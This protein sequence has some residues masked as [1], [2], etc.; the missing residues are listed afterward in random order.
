MKSVRRISLLVII[1]IGVVVPSVTRNAYFLAVLITF[2]I[3]TIL[4][5][6]MDLGLGRLGVLPFGHAGFFGI[7]AYACPLFIKYLA[8]SFWP[9][10][11]LAALLAGVFGLGI[12]YLCFRL[13]GVYFALMSITFAEVLRLVASN[14]RS[15]TRGYM[16]F[17]EIPPPKIDIGFLQL[18][19]DSEVAYYYLTLFFVL[20]TILIIK[21]VMDSKIGK[22][23]SVI[24][25]NEKLSRSIGVNVFRNKMYVWLIATILAGIA[26]GLYAH[27]FRVITPDLLGFYYTASPMI[28]VIVGGRGTISGPVLG[29]FIFITI[30][31]FLQLDPELRMILFGLILVTLS[32]FMPAGIVNSLGTYF[33]ERRVTK[34]GSN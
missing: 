19:F 15:V 23:S 18:Q 21:L 31:E 13:K 14:W 1:L 30:T 10:L 22:A 11:L 27:Y 28:M 6:S 26:G 16:A 7:G 32:L 29:S 5:L 33:Y 17:T 2:Y 20:M 12:G 4:S 24:F 25:Q 9:S 34:C 8:I 3:F